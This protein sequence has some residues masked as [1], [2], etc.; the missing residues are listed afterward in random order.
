MHHIA[1]GAAVLGAL[2]LASA[3]RLEDDEVIE[4]DEE[5][6]SWEQSMKRYHIEPAYMPHG[7]VVPF[8]LI[9]ENPVIPLLLNGYEHVT[10]WI[11][12]SGY[13]YTAIDN[14][15]YKNVNL[16]PTGTVAL[17]TLQTD[18]LITTT[19]P[20]GL[21][22][23][24]NTQQPLLESPPHTAVVRKLK[25]TLETTWGS[26]EFCTK[27]GGILGIS[28]LSHYVTRL[29]YFHRTLTFYDP[30]TF[31][32]KGNGMIFKDWLDVEQYFLVPIT[33][34][35]V[36]VNAAIDSGAF[37]TIMTKGFLEKY[38]RAKGRPFGYE[39]DDGS[40]EASFSETNIELRKKRIPRVYV[41][42]AMIPNT[43]VLFPSC[44][45]TVCPGLLQN[46]GRFDCLFGYNLLRHFVTYLVYKPTPYCIL[47]PVTF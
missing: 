1:I 25:T 4:A 20:P 32:Y 23:D 35:G 11:V 46:G 33:I 14:S 39:G 28:F 10:C 45:D 27:P 18:K 15:V 34:D 12:D 6:E 24:F 30:S 42:S 9:K 3:L 40:V 19:V 21:I 26:R 47:E 29:D 31:V 5:K 13:G 44:N 41:G 16:K 8:R 22:Y 2:G 17:E 37:A 7:Q 43:E 36:T 38:Q